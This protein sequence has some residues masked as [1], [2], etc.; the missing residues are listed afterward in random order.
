MKFLS[1]LLWHWATKK[2]PEVKILKNNI[3]AHISEMSELHVLIQEKIN[4][5]NQEEK[6]TAKI[7]KLNKS[8]LDVILKII[9]EEEKE[10]KFLLRKLI[11]SAHEMEEGEKISEHFKI[12]YDELKKIEKLLLQLK[13]LIEEEKKVV[14]GKFA[15]A[16][17]KKDAFAVIKK[18]NKILSSIDTYLKLLDDQVTEKFLTDYFG[19]S[20]QKCPH[21]HKNFVKERKYN[22]KQGYLFE[23]YCTFCGN[24]DKVL[25]ENSKVLLKR[26]S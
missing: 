1:R 14:K 19:N 12:V 11:K 15:F 23:L 3:K 10:D 26:W 21:C 7:R 8:M 25:I 24:N 20:Q 9:V 6:T 5:F 22:T 18:Q 13:L 16:D 2:N 4:L 17:I